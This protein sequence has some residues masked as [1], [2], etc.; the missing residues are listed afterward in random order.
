[1]LQLS[2]TILSSDTLSSH[3]NGELLTNEAD[4]EAGVHA[5][6][7]DGIN[8]AQLLSFACGA[9][10]CP[11]TFDRKY[12]RDRHRGFP[13]A[14]RHSVVSE[15]PFVCKC[16]QQF[17]KLD[18]LLRHIRRF[19]DLL[20]SFHCE[21]YKH[22][23]KRKDHLVQ[24]LR[25]FHRLQDAQI[26]I[27]FPTRKIFKNDIPV[28]HVKS[29]DHYRDESFSAQPLVLQEKDAPFA[30]KS[31]YTEHM[32]KVHGWSPYSCKV[33]LCD[34]VD[35]NGYFNEKALQKHMQ[36]KHPDAEPLVIQPR[37]VKKVPCGA[38]GCIKILRPSSPSYHR[39][40]C[41]AWRESHPLEIVIQ[42]D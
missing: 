34:K 14:G 8:P 20:P 38:Q 16:D 12:E 2:Q 39:A 6:R 25:H 33:P 3:S 19:Q 17:A 31:D 24:H 23:F 18:T 10:G 29:C 27:Q 22:G 40:S 28:C 32:R 36:E 26:A 11:I 13:H 15:S 30:K 1:M 35:K 7:P 41:P 9:S 4:D 5:A 42:G 21:D 37:E